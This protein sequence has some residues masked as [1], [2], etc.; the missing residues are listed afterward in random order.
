MQF[1]WTINQFRK[2]SHAIHFSLSK[3]HVLDQD[4]VI[5]DKR[6]AFVSHFQYL[7]IIIK[8]DGS[9][10]L[11]VEE[12]EKR[13][14]S[15]FGR[16]CALWRRFPCISQLLQVFTLDSLFVSTIKFGCE[17]LPLQ[18]LDGLQRI[19]NRVLRYM[20]GVCSRVSGTAVQWIIGRHSVQSRFWKA[21]FRL[22]V[23]LLQFRHERY[24]SHALFDQISLLSNISGTWMAEF[25][26]L[27]VDIGFVDDADEIK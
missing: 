18:K 26:K 12:L 8:Q 11:H 16:L 24:E 6:I 25:E 23:Q 10:S 20:L 19:E 13:G 17:L 22:F 7:G 2:K 4:I 1:A 27:V 21:R 5:D 9:L 3:K 14:V 15:C